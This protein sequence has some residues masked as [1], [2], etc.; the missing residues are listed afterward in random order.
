MVRNGFTGDSSSTK[1]LILS[2]KLGIAEVKFVSPGYL[3]SGAEAFHRKAT[4]VHVKNRG[5]VFWHLL[6]FLASKIRA[7]TLR[8]VAAHRTNRSAVPFPQN[9]AI[10]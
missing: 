10:N 4:T 3:V 7:H 8:P 6:Q 1:I 2:R 5:L 9:G